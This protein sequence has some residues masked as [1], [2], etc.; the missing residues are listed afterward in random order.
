MLQDWAR[1]T[2][3][4]SFAEECVVL[5]CFKPAKMCAGR[6]CCTRGCSCSWKRGARANGALANDLMAVGKGR[7]KTKGVCSLSCRLANSGVNTEFSQNSTALWYISLQSGPPCLLLG[8]TD[9]LHKVYPQK[10]LPMF[11]SILPRRLL[12]TM[13]NLALGPASNIRMWQL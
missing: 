8:L 2:T 11:R 12:S 3:S 13:S 7:K 5:V 10:F 6:G 9:C 1:E 4:L